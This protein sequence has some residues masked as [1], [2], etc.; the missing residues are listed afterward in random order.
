MGDIEKMQ[1]RPFKRTFFERLS[2]DAAKNTTEAASRRLYL[3][4]FRG[5]RKSIRM[6][7]APTTRPTPQLIIPMSFQLVIPWRVALQHGPHP[8]HQPLPILKHG[9]FQRRRGV[10]TL[11]GKCGESNAQLWVHLYGMKK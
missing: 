1:P 9:M 2:Q 10:M 7:R 4:S 6:M 11:Y 5:I 8:L 3:M